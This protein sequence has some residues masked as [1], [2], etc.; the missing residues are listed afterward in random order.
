MKKS[1]IIN[2]LY[3]LI[4]FSSI[5]FILI[6]FFQ[7][8]EF[9]YL[10]FKNDY[11]IF[12]LIL[13]FFFI[14]Q[15]FIAIKFYIILKIYSKIRLNLSNWLFIY[16]SGTVF[17]LVI[18]LTGTVFKAKR[19]KDI[20]LSYSEF[21]TVSYFNYFIHLI[22]FFKLL[23]LTLILSNNTY[24]ILY[25]IIFVYLI[26]FGIIL[27]SP[28]FLIM[29][30]TKL[31]NYFRINFFLKLIN[32]INLLKNIFK[33]KK[34]IQYATI[35]NIVNYI[36]AITIYYMLS[37]IFLEI[38]IEQFIILWSCRLIIEKIFFISSFGYFNDILV[39]L[40][41]SFIGNNFDLSLVI[42]VTSRLSI[43][44]TSIFNLAVYKSIKEINKIE[45]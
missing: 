20:G 38:S 30:L 36:I 7:N 8:K 15:N 35:L 16:F 14:F 34:L 11:S 24:L 23:L 26:I 17:N 39:A 5:I 44:I 6:R 4:Y 42:Q 3:L 1:K 29:V 28:T 43:M 32:I 25:S 10:N 21:L 13:F 9:I 18:I 12:I 27:F 40:L 2:L 22:V 31:N 41:S 33:N 19:L 37:T 45:K